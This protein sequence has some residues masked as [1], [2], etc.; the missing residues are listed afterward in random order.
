MVHNGG[1][2]DHVSIGVTD[3]EAGRRF[4]E[5]VLATLG[6]SVIR[7]APSTVGFGKRYPEFW[8]NA[9]DEARAVDPATHICLRASSEDSVNR[10]HQAAIAAGGQDDG[11]PGLRP[12]YTENYY[13][14]FIIDPD[15]NR[16]EAVCFLPGSAED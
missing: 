9:R 12:Q 15:G 13:G 1:M 7:E 6:M 10:F 5:A 3:L 14:A 11:A 2:I 8:L 16:V 4:Y